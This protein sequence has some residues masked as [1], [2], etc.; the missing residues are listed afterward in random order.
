MHLKTYFAIEYQ[1][2]R[3]VQGAY[4]KVKRKHC[5]PEFAFQKSRNPFQLYP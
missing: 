5:L 1:L 4:L 3:L 2:M